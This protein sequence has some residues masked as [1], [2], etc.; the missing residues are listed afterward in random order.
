MVEGVG[1]GVSVEVGVSVGASVGVEVADGVGVSDGG[2]VGKSCSTAVARSAGR[3]W[4]GVEVGVRSA[5]FGSGVTGNGARPVYARRPCAAS[6]TVESV[7][8]PIASAARTRPKKLM[9]H[10]TGIKAMASR[11]V[12][13]GDALRRRRRVIRHCRRR[14]GEETIGGWSQAAGKKRVKR[15]HGPFALLRLR[16]QG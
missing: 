15:R 2:V 5:I 8:S 14:V 6:S 16:C 10:T 3:G 12:P 4:K 1:V 9:A 13:R 11:I 7:P